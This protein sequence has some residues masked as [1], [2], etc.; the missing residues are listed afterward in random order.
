MNAR[1]GSSTQVNPFGQATWLFETDNLLSAGTGT[2]LNS[3]SRARG[4]L[5]VHPRAVQWTYADQAIILELEAEA[6][7]LGS[8]AWQKLEKAR[9]AIDL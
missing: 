5:G 8:L 4:L 6:R 7:S 3:H 9:Y 1:R 2:S